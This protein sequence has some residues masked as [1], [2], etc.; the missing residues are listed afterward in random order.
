MGSSTACE[1]LQLSN[2]QEFKISNPVTLNLTWVREIMGKMI[3]S[4]VSLLS[5]QILK[6]AMFFL[7]LFNFIYNAFIFV[8]E[9]DQ[10]LKKKKRVIAEGCW[11]GRCHL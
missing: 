3:L 1:K 11:M 4:S 8:S 7:L 2:S 6:E 10:F 9:F 5:R